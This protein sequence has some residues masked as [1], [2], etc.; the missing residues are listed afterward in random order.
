MTKNIW[1]WILLSSYATIAYAAEP[2]TALPIEKQAARLRDAG[3]A[4][5]QAEHYG[6][7]IAKLTEAYALHPQPEI[8]YVL[9]QAERRSGH[10]DRALVHYRAFLAFAPTP[11]QGAAAQTQIERCGGGAPVTA[12]AGGLAP[13]EVVATT[14]PRDRNEQRAWYADPLGGALLATGGASVAVGTAVW[15]AANSTIAG[16]N[17]NYAAYEQAR[18][19][20]RDRMFGRIGVGVGAGLVTLGVVRDLVLRT[21]SR[22]WSLRAGVAP[23]VATAGVGGSF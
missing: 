11:E 4:L 22:A 20:E 9:G 19:A 1:L 17:K 12:A 7:A 3:V 2:P 6:E 14:V 15:L 16:A 18:G 21:R 8:Q 5:Y 13:A 10:C 23:G